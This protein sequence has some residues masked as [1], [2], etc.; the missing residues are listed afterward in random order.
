LFVLLFG[1]APEGFTQF[2]I[3][4][5]FA[6]LNDCDTM[7]RGIYIVWWDNNW[8]DSAEADIL[9]DSMIDIRTHCLTEL[10]M[11][12]PPN[13]QNGHYYNVYLHRN[14]DIFPDGW[15]NGQGTDNNGYPFLTLPIGAH[16]DWI[17][18]AHETFHIFQYNANSPGFEYS[19]PSQWFI[20]ASANWYAAT[21][22]PDFEG[23]FLE[24]ESLIRL[25][26]VPLWL[27]FDNFPSYYPENWQ[28]YVHQ[29]AMAMLLF[30]LTEEA[31]V[32]DSLIS[33]SHYQGITEY[34]QEFFFN[35]LGATGFRNHFIDWAAHISNNFD[36]LNQAQRDRMAIEW[37]WVADHN[38]DNRYTET[39]QDEGTNGWYRPADTLVTTSWA[40]N[41]YRLTNS[42]TDT[43]TFQLRG[44]PQGTAGNASYFQGKLVVLNSFTGASFHDLNMSNDQEG[45][46]S[47]SLTPSD[48]AVYFLIASMPAV[49]QGIDQRFSYQMRIDKG[50]MTSIPQNLTP[51]KAEEV[52]RYTPLNQQIGKQDKSPIQIIRYNDGSSRKVYMPPK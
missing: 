41:N 29:Y 42:S 33:Y 4:D 17:N 2:T 21:R 19:G 36:F 31:G 28:R 27:S 25:P 37:N 8:D 39:F 9:L 20:E 46:L 32:S 14:G 15:G 52:G 44:D 45:I 48:T 24:G 47:L 16:Q 5:T 30:Y 51:T 35:A 34:P 18:V 26:H 11:Q 7:T 3:N 22:Y 23:A 1:Q 43:Y 38:D 49:F 13:P 50:P 40:F 12:D 6:N 10:G